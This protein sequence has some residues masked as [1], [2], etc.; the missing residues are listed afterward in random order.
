[1]INIFWFIRYLYLALDCDFP[2]LEAVWIHTNRYEFE[3]CLVSKYIHN[4]L[5]AWGFNACSGFQAGGE[6][7]E[8]SVVETG[9]Q[10]TVY[11]KENTVARSYHCNISYPKN[12]YYVR[13]WNLD[14]EYHPNRE[15]GEWIMD[16]LNFLRPFGEE[17]CTPPYHFEK[18]EACLAEL[19]VK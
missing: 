19:S 5:D 18:F 2:I 15:R 1:M 14:H 10:F 12:S 9:E 8:C 17:F 4:Q 3:A 6:R 16:M 11:V 13:Y 7:R